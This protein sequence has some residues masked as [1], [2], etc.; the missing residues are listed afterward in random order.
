ML[1]SSTQQES[2]RITQN[3][4]KNSSQKLKWRRF[5]IEERT[6]KRRC[7][8]REK[9]GVSLRL[10]FEGPSNHSSNI[11]PTVIHKIHEDVIRWRRADTSD[12]LGLHDASVI[13]WA[14]V[15]VGQKSVIRDN[16]LFVECW[17]DFDC[18][19]RRWCRGRLHF[20]SEISTKQSE[21]IFRMKSE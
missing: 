20:C 8:G 7:D 18:D 10:L 14:R 15:N 6:C 3:H 4:C 16:K 12:G 21:M 9:L 2:I 5:E 11:L 13:E 1:P 17:N 19:W